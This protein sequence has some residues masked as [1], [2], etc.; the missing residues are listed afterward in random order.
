MNIYKNIT[1]NFCEILRENFEKRLGN[2]N[3]IHL[4]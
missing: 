2:F 1:K 3:I 4:N